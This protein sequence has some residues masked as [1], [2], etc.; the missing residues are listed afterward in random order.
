[1]VIIDA[2]VSEETGVIIGSVEL[3]VEWMVFIQTI[4]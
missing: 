4:S 3:D 2:A 1:V